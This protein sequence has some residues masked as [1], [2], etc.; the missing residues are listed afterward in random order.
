MALQTVEQVDAAIRGI[1][2][3]DHPN[4]M[5][6]AQRRQRM[7]TLADLYEVRADIWRE[8]GKAARLND[9]VPEAYAK[10]CAVA[11]KHDRGQVIFFRKQ[12]GA[13]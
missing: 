12:A 7:G 10:A 11:E 6:P 3:G 4:D 8:L 5:K 13:R 1:V 2:D 9:A